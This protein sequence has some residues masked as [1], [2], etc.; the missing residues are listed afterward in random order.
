MSDKKFWKGV[1]VGIL[2]VLCVFAAGT[3]IRKAVTTVAGLTNHIRG[4]DP[5]K[6][7]ERIDR[8]IDTYYL[9]EDEIDEDALTE[10]MYAGYVEAL[11]DPYSVYYTEEETKELLEGTSGE[12]SGI[13][14]VLSQDYSTN[15]ITIV[16]VYED[17]PAKE[18]GLTEGDILYQVD[19]QEI[20]DESLSEVVTWIKGEEGTEVT[21]HVLRGSE[22]LELKAVRRKIEAHTVAYEMKDNQIGY[23]AVSEFDSVT[24][25]Q[26]R[27]A[28]E[29]LETQGMEGL[30]I[31]LRSNPGG[32]LDTVVEMLKLILPK[33]TIVSVRDK[34]GK[35]DVYACDGKNE[36]TKPLVVLVNQYSASASEIFAGAV[37]DYGIGKLAGTTTY[38]KG[39]V[40]Q[41]LPL[42]DGTYLK[43]T[44]AEYFTPSGRNIHGVGIDPD[45][46]IEYEADEED[47]EAD[48]QLDKA[49][50]IINEEIQ[51]K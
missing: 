30:V 10:G 3:G 23:I 36:F 42:G 11:G 50:E 31:D 22:Q 1:L 32:N 16:N 17:S 20:T 27:E 45:I 49:L 40:Q 2:A 35:E 38:G 13:G 44:I 15:I 46:E 12:Y 21:L 19:G 25:D 51:E 29:A 24:Y 33:G 4:E 14:A 39:I 9:Y 37:Q 6:K 47:P 8:I 5:Q 7:L 43:L 48:N 28:L 18:A 26:F 34:Q 41:L